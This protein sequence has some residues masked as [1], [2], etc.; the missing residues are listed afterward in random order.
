[1][2]EVNALT[3]SGLK[4]QSIAK[5]GE[6]GGAT[7]VHWPDGRRGVL[8]RTAGPI[9]MS[10]QTAEVLDAGR[11][12]GLPVPRHELVVQ[13]G[14]GGVAVVQ[15]WLPGTPATHAGPEVID[16]LVATNERFAN[17][18]AD[19]HDVA[20]PPLHLRDS[21]P[22]YWRHES[23]ETYNPRSRAVLRRIREIGGLEPHEMIGDDLVHRDFTLGNILFNPD[24]QVTGVVDWN[25]GV[26][27][28]DRR[29]A[30]VGLL[31]DLSFSILLPHN[32]YGDER[33]ALNRLSEI[34]NETLPAALQLRYWAH[35]SLK[36]LDLTISHHP[37]D[38][39]GIFL[40]VAES[41]LG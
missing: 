28:G 7:Y 21:G 9:E 15:E 3:G 19:R 13:L 24:G 1:M 27:R 17:L 6:Q 14:D 32:E 33:G 20:V 4:L 40:D 18:L 26:A 37:A 25:E 5:L 2:A 12:R 38:T 36:G 11:A 23:L 8:T 34:L 39:V 35:F 16:A 29:F 30:L 10:R 22:A 41:R 31:F